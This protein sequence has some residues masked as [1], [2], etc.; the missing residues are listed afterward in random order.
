[1]E[2]DNAFWGELKSNSPSLE[3]LLQFFW[4]VTSGEKRFQELVNPHINEAAEAAAST[5]GNC[6]NYRWPARAQ[7]RER[8]SRNN[9]SFV[10]FHRVHTSAAVT[11]PAYINQN[12]IDSYST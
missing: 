1:M 11:H 8:A 12:T 2:R 5:Y 7:A 4:H 3:E 9:T 10:P 6:G